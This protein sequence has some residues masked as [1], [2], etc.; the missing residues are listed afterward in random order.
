MRKAILA[1]GIVWGI[2]CIITAIVLFAIG[3][4]ATNPEIIQAA[5]QQNPNVPAAEVEQAAKVLQ[6]ALIVAG[7]YLIIAAA[8]SFVLVGLRNKG[9]GK[10]A[11]IAL[12]VIGVAV[13]ATF[14]AVFFIVDSAVNR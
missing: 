4:N 12:G 9:F 11:G 1:G 8:F 6:Y 5:Q 2:L 13:G 14:P 7:G 3:A 10:G